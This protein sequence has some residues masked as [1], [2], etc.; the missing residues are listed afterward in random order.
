MAIRRRLRNL[1]RDVTNPD[2]DLNKI[3]PD[4]IA[5]EVSWKYYGLTEID[6][7]VYLDKPYTL[8][9]DRENRLTEDS[10]TM[11]VMGHGSYG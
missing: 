11:G 7:Y 9:H 8:S 6:E 2:V 4:F 3:K 5:G 10:L 1:F